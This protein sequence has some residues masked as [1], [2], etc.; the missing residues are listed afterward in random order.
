MLGYTVNEIQKLSI[1][2]TSAELPDSN[3]IL[4][5]LIGGEHIPTYQRFFR[6][7]DGEIFP[8]E[9]NVELVKDQKDNHL[10]E[11]RAGWVRLH[12][13][14]RSQIPARYHQWLS[15]FP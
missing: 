11:C 12:R 2:D 15:R 10:Q 4:R 7:K 9:I 8:V 13:F 6:K 1:K 3:N 14:P 5:R